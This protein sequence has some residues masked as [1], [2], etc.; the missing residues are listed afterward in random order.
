MSKKSKVLPTYTMTLSLSVLDHLGLNLYSSMPA[1]L[2]EVVAN[3]WD[4]D[5]TNVQ[6]SINP[7]TQSINV[8]DD[9]SGM[10]TSEVNARFLNVGYR[11]R[12]EQDV[13][14][15]RFGRHVMGRKGIGKMSLFSIADEIEVW[16][17]VRKG[18]KV[19]RSGLIMR[20]RDIRRQIKSN[21]ERPYH[22]EA[23]DPSE[24]ALDI[25][26]RIILRKLRSRA[27]QLT[28]SALR[29]R[30]A[31][32]FNILDTNFT[33]VINTKPIGLD[34]RRYFKNVEYLWSVGTVGAEY[35]EQATAAKKKSRLKGVVD[36]AKN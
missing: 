7:K 5:A 32:R 13:V 1:V 22:P 27:S 33:I 23:V 20:T 18:R 3:A 25:G 12:E 16:S 8:G 19:E 26:T 14:T 15:P 29:T 35:E 24:I 36:A 4:A 10:S 11:R 2:S 9:G 30:L 34:D 31:R 6:I 28:E 21:S 17:A